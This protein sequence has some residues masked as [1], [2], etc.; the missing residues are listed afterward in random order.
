MTCKRLVKEIHIIGKRVQK[1]QPNIYSAKQ[2]CVAIKT[3][4]Y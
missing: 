3:Y 4:R 1:K 2:Q